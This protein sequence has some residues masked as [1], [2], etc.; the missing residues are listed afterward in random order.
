MQPSLFRPFPG[1]LILSRPRPRPLPAGAVVLSL[2][3]V[4]TLLAR[5]AAAGEAAHPGAPSA[6]YEAEFA[7][8]FPLVSGEHHVSDWALYAA[9]VA[10]DIVGYAAKI[11]L[12]LAPRFEQA[13]G[14]PYQTERLTDDI[15]RDPG[16][17]TS[18]D[19]H[20]RRLAAMTL[21]S[22]GDGAGRRGCQH[23]L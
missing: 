3:A 16:L 2:L 20:R 8:R 14:K 22:D 10:G 4:S 23:P 15:K 21:Y 11:D 5:T 17:R 7:K 13:A 19:D 1:D 12:A 18:F 6:V 9:L